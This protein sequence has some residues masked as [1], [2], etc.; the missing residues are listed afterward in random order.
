M[1]QDEKELTP[2][3]TQP[4]TLLSALG[5]LR[6][7]G[8]PTFALPSSFPGGFSLP[9]SFPPSNNARETG[10]CPTAHLSRGPS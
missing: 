7:R 5:H 6:A 4:V 3:P 1:L 10:K 9:G 8:E 2:A